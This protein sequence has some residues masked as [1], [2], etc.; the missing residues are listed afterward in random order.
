MYIRDLDMEHWFDGMKRHFPGSERLPTFVRLWTPSMRFQ[1]R[2]RPLID[3][4]TTSS[5][6]DSCKATPLMS[7][8]YFQDAS[9]H[10]CHLYSFTIHFARMQVTSAGQLSIAWN[11]HIKPKSKISWYVI[12]EVNLAVASTCLDGPSI[13]QISRAAIEM[14]LKRIVSIT[15][16]ASTC[17][18]A[19]PGPPVHDEGR[20][21][22]PSCGFFRARDPI[23]LYLL[24]KAPFSSLQYVVLYWS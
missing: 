22:D 24:H 19:V 11:S 15:I 7:Q 23:H 8:I 10:S 14:M 13:R 1:S 6:I 12:L 4:D 9:I 21:L 3:V 5:S 20:H 2:R 18:F 16:S 17:N